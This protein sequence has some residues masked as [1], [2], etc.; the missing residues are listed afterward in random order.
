[1]LLLNVEI[2]SGTTLE[3]GEL[4]IDQTNPGIFDGMKA[5]HLSHLHSV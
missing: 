4:D 3:N 2:L 5:S 1:M